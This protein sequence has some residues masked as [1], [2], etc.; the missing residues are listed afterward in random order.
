V[1]TFAFKWNK[2]LPAR[3]LPAPG[4][5]AGEMT[6]FSGAIASAIIQA[7]PGSA[8]RQASLR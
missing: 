3:L 4:R 2:P 8:R 1:A 5:K 7:L 6:E